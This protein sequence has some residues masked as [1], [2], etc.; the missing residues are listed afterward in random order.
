MDQHDYDVPVS[1]AE[2][3]NIE[4]WFGGYGMYYLVGIAAVAGGAVYYQK[5]IAKK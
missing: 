5:V 2:G 4:G 3:D 1:K